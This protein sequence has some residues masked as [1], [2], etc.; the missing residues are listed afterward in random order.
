MPTSP[1]WRLPSPLRRLRVEQRPHPFA[2]QAR[3]L[4]EIQDVEG[5]VPLCG[6][7]SDPE[8]EPLGL[9]R[10]AVVGMKSQ[11]I[12]AVPYTHSGEEIPGLET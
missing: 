6:G 8:E 12:L 10:H 4:H 2:I 5:V 1:P 11:V 7:P 3:P 9:S